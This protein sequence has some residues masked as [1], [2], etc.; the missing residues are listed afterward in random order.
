MPRAEEVMRALE[1]LRDELRIPMLLVTHDRAEA[2]R[3]GNHV[4]PV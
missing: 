2:E 1:A 4:V 3:L